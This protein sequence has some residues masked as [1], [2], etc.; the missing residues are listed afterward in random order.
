MILIG[1]PFAILGGAMAALITYHELRR[2]LYPPLAL[3][4]ALKT[5]L[6]AA[7]VLALLSTSAA[8]LL[9]VTTR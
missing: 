9:S 4:E 3:R 7:G 1:L 2:H 8:W 5:G 6:L